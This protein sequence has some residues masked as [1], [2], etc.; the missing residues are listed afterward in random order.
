MTLA[1][2]KTLGSPF[3]EGREAQ[4][5][6]EPSAEGRE[7]PAPPAEEETQDRREFESRV[8]GDTWS[9]LD[10]ERDLDL[11][12]RAKQHDGPDRHRA[13]GSTPKQGLLGVFTGLRGRV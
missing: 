8:T 11:T 13:K 12:R 4:G 2:S 10:R 9:W 5:D 6:E 3:L 1:Q 7:T